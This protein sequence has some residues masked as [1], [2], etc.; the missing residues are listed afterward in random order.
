[1]SELKKIKTGG[2]PVRLRV[3]LIVIFEII[4]LLFYW[5]S[6]GKIDFKTMT[7]VDFYLT[8]FLAVF[9]AVMIS[10]YDNFATV[11][12]Y[13]FNKSTNSLFMR[14][15]YASVVLIFVLVIIAIVLSLVF[16]QEV[17]QG[18]VLV[19]FRK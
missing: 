2:L 17:F 10:W 5:K 9:G 8:I 1:M 18:D 19:F 14:I 15:F 13:I 16:F 7:S 6:S 4:L 11:I 3:V 12:N